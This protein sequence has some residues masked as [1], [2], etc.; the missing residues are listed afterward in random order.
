MLIC[1]MRKKYFK[2]KSIK[3]ECSLK[4]NID[5]DDL[6]VVHVSMEFDEDSETDFFPQNVNNGLG[7]ANFGG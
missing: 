5:T 6:K 7:M 2:P 3:T 1:L 4:Y